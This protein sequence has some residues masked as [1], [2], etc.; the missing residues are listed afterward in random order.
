MS[1]MMTVPKSLSHAGRLLLAAIA[2]VFCPPAIAVGQPTT[3]AVDP[4]LVSSGT[5]EDGR[6]HL[7]PNKSSV[8]VTKVPFK[9]ISVGAPDIADVNP[10]GPSN[11]LITGKKPGTTQVIV[12]DDSDRIQVID[13]IVDFYLEELQALLRNTFPDSNIQVIA[14]NSAILLRGRVPSIQVSEQAQ[15]LAKPFSPSVI[16]MLEVAG[17]QQVMLEV[18]FAEVSKAATNAL[19]VNFGL[20]DGIGIAGSNIGQIAPLGLM[21]LAGRPGLS[22]PSGGAAAVTLFGKGEVGGTGFITFIRAMRENSLLRVLAEPNLITM[23][24]KEASFLAGGEFPVPTPQTGGGGDEF[25]AIT[26][27]YKEYGVRLKFLPVVL[28]NGNIHLQVSPEV[29]DLDYANAITVGGFQI[30]GIR[31]RRVST[32][33]ELSDGQSF[34]VA[35]LLNDSTFSKKESTPVLGD[36]PVLGALFRST[37]YERKETELVVLVTV[38]LVAAINPDKVSGLPGE[39]WRHPTEAQLFM[40]GDLGEQLPPSKREPASAR[41]GFKPAHGAPPAKSPSV[42]DAPVHERE[43]EVGPPLMGAPAEPQF[44]RAVPDAPHSPEGDASPT[45]EPAARQA[46]DELAPE[47]TPSARP[48]PERGM[49]EVPVT[50]RAAPSAQPLTTRTQRGHKSSPVR[51]IGP[52]DPTD[53]VPEERPVETLATTRPAEPSPMVQHEQPVEPQ[54]PEIVETSVAEN[55]PDEAELGAPLLTEANE[56]ALIPLPRPR[57]YRGAYGFTPA[58]MEPV[59]SVADDE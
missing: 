44:D 33:I 17:G 38:H 42:V 50:V 58:P 25:A 46:K 55:G 13:V 30:P 36:I 51:F 53:M 11:L 52:P 49:L 45:T 9:Q 16:N 12:W 31:T 28:G 35:G 27:D 57:R 56:D 29:S 54:A 37:R 20:T 23:S 10:T 59:A 14:A 18:K 40:F 39:R 41:Q 15:M 7:L 47:V 48:Q 3:Q 21:D 4:T 32:S 24:G 8:I 2:V 6:V 1:D 43:P 26:V 19:G 34:A 22:Y 5:S